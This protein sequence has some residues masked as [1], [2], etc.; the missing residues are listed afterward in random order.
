MGQG[1]GEMSG[2]IKNLIPEFIKAPVRSR[3][4]QGRVSRSQAGQDLWVFTEVFDGKR[5]GFFVDIGA[6]DGV[7]ISNTFVLKTKYAWKG[8]CVEANPDIFAQLRKNRRAKCVNACVDE[9]AGFVAFRK[10]GKLGRIIATD[11]NDT[12]DEKESELITIETATLEDILNAQDAPKE[13]DYLSM[14]IEGAEERALRCFS[15]KNWKFRCITIEY[16][17]ALVRGILNDNGYRLVKEI[18]GLD[19]FYVHYEFLDQYQK[20]IF[21]FYK[22]KYL[23]IRIG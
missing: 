2:V 3:L 22:K 11:V 1:K 19:C 14:D 15:F 12:L 5:D 17:T 13:I 4:H 16:P 20:N 21:N 7:E 18:P 6:Y 8:I 9:K 10:K 23:A